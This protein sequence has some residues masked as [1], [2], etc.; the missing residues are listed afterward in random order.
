MEEKSNIE[1]ITEFA[2]MTRRK[3]YHEKIPY[4]VTGVRRI[5][6]FKR[7][8]YIPYN[9]QERN[10]FYI[11][12]SD[13]HA[14]VGYYTVFSGAF[15]PISSR[16]KGKIN[17][18]SKNIIDKV[19]VFSKSKAIKIGSSNFDS[20]AVITGTMDSAAKKLLSQAKIQ[21]QLLNALELP[22]FLNIS[23]NEYDI[24]FVPELKGKSYLSIINPK[25]WDFEKDTIEEI[26]RIVEKIKNIISIQ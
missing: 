9:D 23:I 13:P 26:F 15:I 2:K 22:G 1:I 8:I 18:R 5:R 10:N 17:I 16:I 4:P 25:G 12:F 24:N 7:L 11:W 21:E 6:K 19:N 3:V 20:K 14:T